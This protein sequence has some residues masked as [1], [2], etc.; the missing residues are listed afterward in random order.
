MV[1]AFCWAHVRRDFIAVGKG[2]PELKTWALAWLRGIRELYRLNRLRLV[3]D[4]SVAARQQADVDLRQA[5][6]VMNTQA[7][8]ELADAN[9]REPCGKVLHSLQEHWLGLTRFL[10][11]P[12]IPMDNNASE[13]QGRGPA[14]G[15]KNYY[16]SGALWSGRLAAMVF[17][18]LATLGKWNLNPRAWLTW[19][20]NACAEAGGTAP[21]DITHFLPWNLSPEQRTLLA[22][23][24][25][26][27][28]SS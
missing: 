1:L 23:E 7:A 8:V 24:P 14:L 18:L 21:K 2:W 5:I 27:P 26:P 17:S 6:Q 9:L 4:Q 15:R 11:D 19:Y 20:L 12:C 28:N 22:T 16:G 10:D 25:Q 13:R 3:N